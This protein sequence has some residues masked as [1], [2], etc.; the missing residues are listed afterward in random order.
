MIQ[1]KLK[2]KEVQFRYLANYKVLCISLTIQKL[3]LLEKQQHRNY[4]P[5]HE[6]ICIL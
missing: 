3:V 6:Q 2:D 5:E 1:P 4:T